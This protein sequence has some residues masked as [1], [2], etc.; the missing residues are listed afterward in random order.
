MQVRGHV[1]IG[2]CGASEIN[3]V[4]VVNDGVANDDVKF[5]A[6]AYQYEEASYYGESLLDYQPTGRPS[7]M[8]LAVWPTVFQCI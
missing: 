2:K 4:L 8:Y 3:F 1:D 7:V 5:E 6:V